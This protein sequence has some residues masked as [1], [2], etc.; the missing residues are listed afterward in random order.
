VAHTQQ[1]TEAR[2][3]YQ[4]KG[5]LQ[6]GSCTSGM[7][8]FG[9]LEDEALHG[10]NRRDTCCLVYTAVAQKDVARGIKAERCLGSGRELAHRYGECRG[11]R[12]YIKLEVRCLLLAREDKSLR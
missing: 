3:P 4:C 1:D 7:S 8:R 10:L 2:L 11:A 9:V 5:G 6:E 12:W